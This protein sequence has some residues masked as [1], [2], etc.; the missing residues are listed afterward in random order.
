MT[1]GCALCEGLG[2][3]CQEHAHAPVSAGSI[4]RS[5]RQQ[6]GIG[7]R[8]LARRAGCSHVY[9]GKIERGVV[10]PK[11]WRLKNLAYLL[12]INHAELCKAAARDVASRAVAR[13]EAKP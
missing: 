3:A 5:A 7:Q 6:A 12:G 13:W 10:V 8:E 2:R 11:P 9:L 4:I 1:P